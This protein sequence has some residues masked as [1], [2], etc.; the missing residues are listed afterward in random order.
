MKNNLNLL[1]VDNIECYTLPYGVEII[2]PY[3]PIDKVIWCPCDTEDSNFVKMLKA[4][5]NKVI[6]SHIDLGQDC[7]TY[8]PTEHWDILIT[9]PPFKNKTKY[10]ERFMSFNKPF[11][12]ILPVGGLGDNGIPNLYLKQNKDIELLIPDRRME[13]GNQAQTGIS[14]KSIYYCWKILPKQII[15]CKLNKSVLKDT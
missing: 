1:N 8:Q 12:V 9:N 11:A 10:M 2:L 4:R 7:F 5:G 14:F 15:F 3:I 13:F 6:Y